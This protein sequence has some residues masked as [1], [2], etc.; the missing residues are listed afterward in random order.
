MNQAG[1]L[2][3]TTPC[4]REIAMTRVFEAPRSLVFDALTKPALV[5]QWL[6][7]P[8]GWSMPVCEIDLK[9]GG[10]YR[11]VWR[12][13]HG[14]EMGVGGVCRE[15][16][17]PERFVATETFDQPWYPGEALVTNALV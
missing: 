17:V 2:R 5:T 12:G 15:I 7:G 11:F 16:V 3:V 10:A 8:P 14:T 13:A 1:T 6:L 4:D 9:V